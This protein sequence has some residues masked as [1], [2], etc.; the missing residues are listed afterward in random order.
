M[1][2]RVVGSGEDNEVKW[3][4]WWS[5]ASVEGS[6]RRQVAARTTSGH[7]E[8]SHMHSN[9]GKT[10]VLLS[11]HA[12]AMPSR[13]ATRYRAA[14][15]RCACSV[16]CDVRA[17]WRAACVWRACGVRA[18]CRA[19]RLSRGARCTCSRGAIVLASEIVTP[20]SPFLSG[21]SGI[22]LTH[23]AGCEGAHQP[24]YVALTSPR[25]CRAMHS[26]C[27]STAAGG[28]GCGT[29]GGVKER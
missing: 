19:V 2:W 1:E 9:M 3:W 8:R 20:W 7:S 24:S 25:C 21:Y 6:P 27:G 5:S 11:S 17:A 12:A 28:S 14:I 13:R 4:V 16:A 23:G 22:G 10:K 26:L 15:L 29:L 18:A